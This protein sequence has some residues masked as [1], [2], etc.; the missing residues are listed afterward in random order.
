MILYQLNDQ[1]PIA[2]FLKR[3]KLQF[4]REFEKKMT[5]NL[6]RVSKTCFVMYLY[7]AYMLKKNTL[8]KVY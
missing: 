6:G 5:T 4:Q 2:T 7:M 1:L 8:S 3:P